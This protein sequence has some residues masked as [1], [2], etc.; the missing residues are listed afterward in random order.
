MNMRSITIDMNKMTRLM[1]SGVLLLACTACGSHSNGPSAK[2]TPQ[3]GKHPIL[4]SDQGGAPADTDWI[5]LS[6]AA[7]SLGLRLEETDSAALL[8]F[9]D[10]MFQVEPSQRSAVSFGKQISLS[11]PPIRQNGKIHMTS[12]ALGDLLQTNVR[13]DRATGKLRI[14]S[15]ANNGLGRDRNKIKQPSY[16]RMNI[17]SIPANRSELVSYARQYLGVRYVFGAAPYEQSR[18]FDCS[19]FTQ[20]VFKKY[21]ISL[22]RLARDQ[23]ERGHPV[24]RSDLQVGDLVFFSVPGRFETDRIP[25]HVGIYIGDGKIIH[26]WGEPG[27][28]ISDVDSGYWKDKILSMRRVQ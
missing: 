17:L 10:V 2:S 19:S 11:Q 5:P 20:H 13:Y 26:T 22:P 4:R 18:A 7:E 9:T 25:G 21:G 16:K 6:K 12:E 14:D 28:Q 23:A 27:V 24:S 3:A 1:L 8:G 15:L